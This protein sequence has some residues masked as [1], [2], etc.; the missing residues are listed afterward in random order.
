MP[1]IQKV[2]STREE[3]LGTVKIVFF[4]LRGSGVT[5]IS[6]LSLIWCFSVPWHIVTFTPSATH[7]SIYSIQQ[8]WFHLLY[9]LLVHFNCLE[10]SSYPE[11]SASH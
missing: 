6:L 7:D 1:A 5:Y 3:M 10:K 9:H 11:M 8:M 4:D 2:T